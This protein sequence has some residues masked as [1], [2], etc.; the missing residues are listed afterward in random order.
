MNIITD[1]RLNSGQ[2]VDEVYP[3][4]YIA[5]HHTAGES[6]ESS[7]HWW[8]QQPQRIGT[9][10]VVDSNGDVYETF[11]PDKWAF[12]LGVK[13]YSFLDKVSVGIELSSPGGLIKNGD[14]FHKYGRIADSTVYNGEVF[15]CGYS[16]RGYRYFAAYDKLQ[17]QSAIRLI[18]YLL[19]RYKINPV[20]LDNVDDVVSNKKSLK[21]DFYSGIFSH[22]AVRADK[23]DLHPGFPYEQLKV[24]L[25][26]CQ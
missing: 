16:W 22:S 6:A 10:Y 4:R 15:D 26:K 24:M 13:G 1:L 2:Y 25:G 14:S 3:K 20:L 9:A 5:L 18:N 19:C 11:D 7:I 17:I 12:H 21:A 8:N 23:T